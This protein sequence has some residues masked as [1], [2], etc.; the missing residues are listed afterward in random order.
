MKNFLLILILTISSY[1]G[2][3]QDNLKNVLKVSTFSVIDFL[4]PSVDLS[5][6]RF[7]SEKRSLQFLIG[8]LLLNGEDNSH[9]FKFRTEYRFY[10]KSGLYFAPEIF[11]MYNHYTTFA[12]FGKQYDTTGY[13]YV[14][15]FKIDKQVIALTGKVGYEYRYKHF[16]FDIFYGM[17]I[18]FRIVKRYNIV[19][20]NPND[21]VIEPREL[22]LR[23]V[24]DRVNPIAF[25][26]SF[27]IKLGYNF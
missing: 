13:N 16:C 12:A 26:L 7:I 21:E 9:G 5:Y 6:E 24:N 2:K 10:K 22:N 25:N 27:N 17:G 8:Y 19:L 15:T 23:L 4:N 18:R 20:K 11:Y 14:D 3:C 1:Q